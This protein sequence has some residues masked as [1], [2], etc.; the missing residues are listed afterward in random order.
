MEAPAEELEYDWSEARS[1]EAEGLPR[2]TIPSAG[3][4]ISP[5]LCEP[6]TNAAPA[7]ENMGT[8]GVNRD[9]PANLHM[10]TTRVNR[11]TPANSPMGTPGVNPGTPVNFP[12]GIANPGLTPSFTVSKDAHV[13]DPGPAGEI[14]ARRQKFNV[15]SAFPE[16][17]ASRSLCRQNG[18]E[19]FIESE[20]D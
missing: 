5:T 18:R 13:S 4:P 7:H 16:G 10:G 20:V 6:L 19:E 15:G 2:P 12:M 11:C 17:V 9:T 1:E 14:R 3:D 8:P